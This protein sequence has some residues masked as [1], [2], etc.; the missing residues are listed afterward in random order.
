[1]LLGIGDL[2]ERAAAWLL[3]RKRVEVGREI[4]GF[5][6]S[7]RSLA[8]S[9][10]ELLPARDRSLVA[11]RTLRLT[12]AGVPEALAARIGA[13]MFLAAALE[14]ADLAERSGQPLERAA[15]V[16][17]EVGAQFA[18]DEMRG[19]A[20]RLSTETVW[21]KQAVEA[22]VDDL[23]SLQA[24]L[25]QHVLRSDCALQPDPLAA[26]SAAQ[27]ATLVS[28]EPLIRELRATAIPDLAMLVVVGRQLRRALG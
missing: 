14:I 18:L 25:A 1:M 17:Y 8:G 7:T 23:F 9:L 11:E 26:W 2:I 5:A 6:P 21:Q 13:T 16:Y 10:F 24:D 4:A 15:Q 19:A 28:V 12:E 22:V 20:R 27:W 3:Y